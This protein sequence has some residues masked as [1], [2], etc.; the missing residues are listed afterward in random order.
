MWIFVFEIDIINYNRCQRFYF[1]FLYIIIGLLVEN[2]CGFVNAVD[3][4]VTDTEIS[5]MST[6]ISPSSSLKQEKHSSV[7]YISSLNGKIDQK[8]PV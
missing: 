6:V 1:T 5:R 8:H 7:I 2:W 3:S 4:I